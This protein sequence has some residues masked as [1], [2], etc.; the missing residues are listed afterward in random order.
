MEMK[1]LEFSTES[2]QP[3]LVVRVPSLSTLAI[4]EKIA[5]LVK[6]LVYFSRKTISA[7]Q[8]I[9][10]PSFS[11]VKQ[12]TGSLL[13]VAYEGSNRLTLKNRIKAFIMRLK[14]QRRNRNFGSRKKF[15]R[16]IIY[17]VIIIVVFL[18]VKKLAQSIGGTSA[19]TSDERIEVQKAKASIDLNKEFSFPLRDS[20]G[21][22]VSSIIYTLE[23]A[24]LR[25]EIIVK[26]QRATAIKGRTF[27]IINLKIANEYNQAIEIDTRD[28]LRLTRN[29][30]K[31]E[32]LAPD[33]HNDPVEVQAISTKLTRLGFPINDTDTNLKLHVGEIAG[34]KEV[35]DLN[36]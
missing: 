36:F 35:I 15:G 20:A 32:K 2:Q 30:N 16:Y 3:A 34:G 7:V 17:A 6:L 5:E 33:I 19:Q 1:K 13:S 27:L 31:E 9:A 21:D 4:K 18:A 29:D 24:E 25:D 12:Q 22:E 23:S 8:A 11:F 28:Y 26:G 10:I 14:E